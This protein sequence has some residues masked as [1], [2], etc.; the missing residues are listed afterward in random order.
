MIYKAKEEK[1]LIYRQKKPQNYHYCH[2]F[3]YTYRYRFHEVA[4][5]TVTILRKKKTLGVE[6]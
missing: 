1:F 5:K 2:L 3:I 4:V 6:T